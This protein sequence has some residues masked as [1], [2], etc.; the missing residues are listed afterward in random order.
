MNKSAAPAERQLFILSE[1]EYSSLQ[2]VIPTPEHK[3]QHKNIR[4][5]F[6]ILILLN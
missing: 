6:L 1:V 5:K 2:R 3:Q 4:G